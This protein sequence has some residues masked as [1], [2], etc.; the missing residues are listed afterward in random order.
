MLAV[1]ASTASEADDALTTTSRDR[2][3]FWASVIG[4]YALLIVVI[5]AAARFRTDSEFIAALFAFIV[6]GWL[7]YVIIQAMHESCHQARPG[8]ESW[9]AAF[10]LFYA[11]GLTWAYRKIHYAHHLSFNSDRDPDY[12]AYVRFPTSKGEL[13]TT[14]AGHAT[15]YAA[16]R[17][18]L[19]Q[20]LG[21]TGQTHS[22]GRSDRFLLPLTQ[23][24]IAAAFTL[25]ASPIDYIVFWL[26]PIVTVGKV[27]GYLRILAEHGD[28]ERGP[29]LRTFRCRVI[30]G[31]I[32]GPYGFI[33][34]AEHHAR[35]NVPF[36]SLDQL[37]SKSDRSAIEAY[38][39]KH[40][41]WFDVFEGSH[42]RLIARWWRALPARSN[43]V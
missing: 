24:G 12:P 42:L 19:E 37:V 38:A 9:I 39:A 6:I 5:A 20:N 25:L 36:S 15:G 28:P 23:L 22:G 32:L 17:Q 41:S 33:R 27:L 26:A 11:I 4:V 1:S 18:L 29:A 8:L 13:L 34:H 14:L 30:S 40:A 21:D 10:L 16:V 31:V 7:Q 43:V 35:M 2:R 3:L